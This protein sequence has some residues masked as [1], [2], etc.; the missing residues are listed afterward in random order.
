MTVSARARCEGWS[1][2][3]AHP[4]DGTLLVRQQRCYVCDCIL[5]RQLGLPTNLLG[6][7]L[8]DPPWLWDGAA[9]VAAL[10]PT[11][12]ELRAELMFEGFDPD[13]APRYGLPAR[14]RRGQRRRRGRLE[15][16]IEVGLV[17]RSAR[18]SAGES[19]HDPSWCA[20]PV[21]GTSIEE[22]LASHCSVVFNQHVP[23]S[24]LDPVGRIAARVAEAFARAG[25]LVV[26]CPNCGRVQAVSWRVDGD[27]P[28]GQVAMFYGI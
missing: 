27:P 17:R 26:H 23:L 7:P 9:S 3:S 18:M 14:V 24:S 6:D 1:Q 20:V 2:I 5:A 4:R 11:P 28:L 10:I 19:F 25:R 16:A 21:P 8:S 12:P 15:S 22:I 13:G